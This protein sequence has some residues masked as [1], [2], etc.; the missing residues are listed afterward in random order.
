MALV[1]IF[2]HVCAAFSIYRGIKEDES[3]HGDVVLLRVEDREILLT[4][5]FSFFS[6]ISF[7]IKIVFW[8]V[9]HIV[10]VNLSLALIS[11]SESSKYL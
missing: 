3:H 2:I 10:T 4:D 7:S 8:F 11:Q 1:K 5:L 9:M 6:A